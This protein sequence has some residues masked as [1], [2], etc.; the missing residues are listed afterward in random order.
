MASSTAI[1]ADYRT[2]LPAA[3]AAAASQHW[4][5][6]A[7]YVVATP[8]GN[9]ADMSLRALYVLHMADAIACE[10]TR[11]TAHLLQQY[12]IA[13]PSTRLLAL[14]QHNEH[15]ASQAVLTR[16]QQGQR[17]AYVSDAG[18][19]AISDPGA[20]LAAAVQAAGLR[21]IPVPGASSITAALSVAGVD[22]AAHGHAQSNGVAGLATGW[23]FAGFLPVRTQERQRAIGALQ[24]EA[25][26][27][28]L[29]EAPH[30]MAAL[31]QELAVCGLRLVTL[32]REIT[33]QHET[34]VTLPACELPQWLAAAPERIRGEFVLVLHPQPAR[35]TDSTAAQSPAG[36]TVQQQRVLHLLLEEGL[37]TKSAARLAAEITDA[38][39]KALYAAALQWKS[40]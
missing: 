36:L 2:A 6:S 3:I 15:S 34:V 32:A 39:R 23:I 25:R 5:A 1:G 7:L 18:T 33:K 35:H 31:A 20:R 30:R 11:H 19:P 4:P 37:S 22:P 16:L 21:V 13:A 10:D 8:I 40:A 38:P 12:G 27:V 9:L 17:L 26:A 28:I 24:Q 14:H 29:L